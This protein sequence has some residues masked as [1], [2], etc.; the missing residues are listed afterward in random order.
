MDEKSYIIITGASSD[1]G[2]ALSKQLLSAHNLILL[3]INENSILNTVSMLKSIDTQSK[4]LYLSIDFNDISTVGKTF[5]DFLKKHDISNIS[6]LVHIAGIAPVLPLKS[7]EIDD[8]YKIFN[9][10]L[11]SAVEIIRV[12]MKKQ[13]KQCMKSIVFISSVAAHFGVKA[14]IMYSVSKAAIEAFVRGAA[15][16]LAPIR[17]NAIAPGRVKTNSMAVFI[18]DTAE[19]FESKHLLGGG[20]AENI[21]DMLYF[22]LSEKASWITGQT[23]IIDGGVSVN[24][25]MNE[26]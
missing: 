5:Q 11:L 12:L 6:G 25:L 8:W 7:T 23:Y 15:V 2:A 9:I 22:L 1:M 16:E 18:D 4:T 17:V 26:K 20:S 19:K 14:Q 10:N 24:A 21:A 3:D 13:Y